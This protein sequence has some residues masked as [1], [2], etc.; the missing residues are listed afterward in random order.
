MHLVLVGNHWSDI[1]TV[2]PTW[3][4]VVL[5]VGALY[6]FVQLLRPLFR[7][8]GRLDAIS[9]HGYPPPWAGAARALR[10]LW[11]EL[12]K[13]PGPPDGPNLHGRP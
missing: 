2:L 5:L 3:L 1:V 9:R 7:L 13:R 6:G 10:L 8:L 4:T 11:F 12:V